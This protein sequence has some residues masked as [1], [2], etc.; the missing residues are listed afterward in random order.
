MRNSDPREKL[1]TAWQIDGQRKVKLRIPGDVR[2]NNGELSECGTVKYCT[3]CG[4]PAG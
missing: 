1:C 3:A 4:A 2:T